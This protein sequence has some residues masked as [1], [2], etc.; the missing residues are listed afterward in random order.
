L[1]NYR[2]RET[3]VIADIDSDTHYGDRNSDQNGSEVYIITKKK[4][5]MTTT[6][7]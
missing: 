3:I 2:S 6:I 5:N 1:D 7:L 4:N